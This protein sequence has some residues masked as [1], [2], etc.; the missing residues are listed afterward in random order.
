[1][2]TVIIVG[3]GS[4]VKEGISN[5]LW[6][7]IKGMDIITCNNAIQHIPYPPKYA[8][9]LD[10]TVR[11]PEVTKK[12][13]ETDCIRVTQQLHDTRDDD[14]VVRF[15][16]V[17]DLNGDESKL[18]RGLERGI[19]FAG[20]R[21]FTGIFAISLALYAGYNKIFLLGFD[22]NVGKKGNAEW[23]DRPDKA[24]ISGIFMRNKSEARDDCAEHHDCFKGKADIINVSK[25][26]LIPSFPKIS[27]SDFF[28]MI[29][30]EG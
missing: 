1:M 4:S 15:P 19:L 24:D 21:M 28:E 13:L 14:K 6:D 12:I 20:K 26:S 29:K 11:D 9:W 16:I 25:I 30:Q 7:K 27:Y 18:T 2:P 3:G 8:C 23:Y 22:W 10:T 17:K 5:G